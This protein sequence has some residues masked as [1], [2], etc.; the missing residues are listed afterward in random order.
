MSKPPRLADVARESKVSLTTVSL[1]LR[2]KPGIH[3]ATRARVLAAAQALGYQ[4]PIP[5]QTESLQR[6]GDHQRSLPSHTLGVL[7]KATADQIAGFNPF[8]SY[9]VAGIEQEC[10]RNR[11][12]LLYA[13]LRVDE[14]NLPV[15]MPIVLTEQEVEGLL[16]VGTF[17]DETL[18]RVLASKSV[19]VVLV[20]AYSDFSYDSVVSDNLRG[21]HQVISHLVQCGHHHIG[22]VGSRPTAYPSIRERREG[23][24]AAL[25][26]NGIDETYFADSAL[27]SDEATQAADDLLRRHPQIT[28]LFGCNDD[29][30]IAAMRSAQALGKRVPQDISIVGFDD[31]DFAQ[32]VTPAL[33]TMRVD[34]IGM[35]RMAVYLLRNR[36]Q[37][38]DAERVTAQVTPRLMKRES[39]STRMDQNGS[40]YIS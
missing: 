34:K 31:I 37:H 35:G 6:N 2:E 14:Y 8:Y 5:S 15:D 11:I 10:S 25:Q 22:I 17:L 33:T 28:A 21:A 12:N 27:D 9:V 30:A 36:I 13:T 24:L 16:L 38:P 23:Y 3:P 29:M 1:V 20:D 39:V 18:Q 19:P 4:Y 7:I 26:E 40:T 32:H